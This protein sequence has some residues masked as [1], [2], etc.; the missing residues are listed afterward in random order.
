MCKADALD[1]EKKFKEESFDALHER[2]EI[3]RA[4]NIPM[5]KLSEFLDYMGEA[6]EGNWTL[7]HIFEIYKS[8]MFMKV[9]THNSNKHISYMLI[10]CCMVTCEL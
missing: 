8:N 5:S 9:Y 10:F 1:V 6:Y 7:S 4:F 2:C 3:M